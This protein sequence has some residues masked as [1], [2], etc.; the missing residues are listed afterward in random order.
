MPH[1][2]LLSAGIGSGL[3]LFALYGVYRIDRKA[4][5]VDLGALAKAAEVGAAHDLHVAESD[6][7]EFGQR[8]LDAMKRH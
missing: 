4:V 3:T 8:A 6:L 5:K 2:D 1:L 7:A